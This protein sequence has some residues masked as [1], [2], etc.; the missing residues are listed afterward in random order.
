[1]LLSAGGA[2]ADVAWGAD[3]LAWTGAVTQVEGAGGGGLVPWALIAGL[4]TADQIGGSAFFTYAHTADF[5]TRA[6]GIAVG[7][8]DRVELSFA[9]QRFDAFS[10]IPGLTLG[11]DVF[12][13]KCRIL[14]D[15]VFEPDRWLPQIA[16]GLLLKR[17]LDFDFVPHAVGAEKG[18]DL[19]VYVAAT[20]V[21][22]AALAGRNVI[23]D[24][25]LRRSRANQFGLLG[26]GG[27][28]RSGYRYLPEASVGILLSEKILVGGEWRSK[29]DNLGVFSEGS[30]KDAF[31]AW[32]P[33]KAF[34]ATFAWV[35]LGL[36]AGKSAQ[37]GLYAS[38][39]YG[40]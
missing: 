4:G 19:D 27:D 22:F 12:G 21:Y 33:D 24:A 3:R 9:R 6:G 16:V 37:R 10:V 8:Y 38:I 18:H 15:A 30:A 29:P 25:T 34:T 2:A 36:I 5:S 11:Q 17:T 14:G 28:R 1:M 26:F 20:K 32:N 13:L 31:V 23:V 35:D 7:L 40:F 39:W